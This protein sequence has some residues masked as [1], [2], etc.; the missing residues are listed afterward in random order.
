[1]QGC[2]WE[3]VR[4][5]ERE[6]EWAT[7]INAVL[8][9]YIKIPGTDKVSHGVQCAKRDKGGGGLSFPS[10]ICW[11]YLEVKYSIQMYV[12]GKRQIE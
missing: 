5:G 11:F 9:H 4:E 7:A 1:M 10:F 2:V 6:R 12:E 3:R 8:M